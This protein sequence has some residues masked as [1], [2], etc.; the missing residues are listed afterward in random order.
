VVEDRARNPADT[1]GKGRR[2]I[3]MSTSFWLLT[4]AVGL[5]LS[6][7]LVTVV[8]FKL[9]G[10]D[11]S[12]LE[13]S[14]RLLRGGGYKN[15]APEELDSILLEGHKKLQIIDL[16]DAKVAKVAPIPNS[17]SS[18]FDDFLKDVVVEGKYG[19]DDPIVL[20]CDTGLMSRVAADILIEDE[21]FTDVY[22]LEGGY[23]NWK[24]WQERSS[25]ASGCCAI[26]HLARCC[27]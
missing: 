7:L 18:P 6:G 20:A 8:R 13:F 9:A 27:G 23:E 11:M 5:I 12:F 22:N 16:R 25:N 15:I 26:G 24:R 21:N 14:R 17:V 19:S 2:R 10:I 1:S 3:S 4:F